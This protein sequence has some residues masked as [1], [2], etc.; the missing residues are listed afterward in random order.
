MARKTTSKPA[1]AAALDY[2]GWKAAAR[3]ILKEQH[4]VSA[5]TIRERDWRNVYITGAPPGAGAEMAYRNSWNA[6][7]PITG[8]RK[9]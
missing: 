8:R 2:A 1:P 6:R 3:A 9:R 4:G 7:P 5:P